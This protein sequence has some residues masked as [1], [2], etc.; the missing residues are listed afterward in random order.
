MGEQ[1]LHSASRDVKKRLWKQTLLLMS[2]CLLFNTFSRADNYC[3]PKELH[4]LL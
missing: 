4:A 2:N 1:Q 3:V